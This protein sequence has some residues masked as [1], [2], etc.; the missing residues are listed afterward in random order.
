MSSRYFLVLSMVLVLGLLLLPT[1]VF[2]QDV[3]D[4]IHGTVFHDKNLDGLQDP[5]EDGI[6]GVTVEL[7]DE[8]GSDV[9]TA[10]TD[11]DGYYEFSGL[12]PGNYTVVELDPEDYVST[13]PNEVAVVLSGTIAVEAVDFGDVP[14]AEL[15]VITGTVY[16]DLNRTRLCHRL[17]SFLAKLKR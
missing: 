10:T 1:A 12:E 14:I 4:A 17:F 5:G 8:A 11:I 3:T 15:G 7:Y 9:A 6:L 13:T 16:D 2:A